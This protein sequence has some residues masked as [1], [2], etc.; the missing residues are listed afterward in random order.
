MG[1]VV[2]FDQVPP[3]LRRHIR[4][5]QTNS[6]VDPQMVAGS[7][8]AADARQ[9]PFRNPS[10][11]A[12]PRQ[13]AGPAGRPEPAAS[14]PRLRPVVRRFDKFGPA[15]ISWPS[16]AA[17]FGPRVEPR[18]G[19]L[20]W[21]WP[22]ISRL[23]ESRHSGGDIASDRPD[24]DADEVRK[25]RV[26]HKARKIRIRELGRHVKLRIR[27]KA[28]L[29]WTLAH[30]RACRS[31]ELIMNMS[32]RA[33]AGHDLSH[34]SAVYKNRLFSSNWQGVVMQG[35]GESHIEFACV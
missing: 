12:R 3:R 15:D 18:E 9:A 25:G 11:R 27:L 33:A 20:N 28:E 13:W 31:S 17:P 14:R 2:E 19:I 10:C 24:M 23:A 22:C 6:G 16:A 8:R 32:K 30:P 34:K 29:P 7:N 35:S 5:L 4:R 1:G 26:A 21:D